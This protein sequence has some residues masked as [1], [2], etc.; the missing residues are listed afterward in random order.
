MY[1][2]LLIDRA[3]FYVLGLRLINSL[4]G[5]L[6]IFFI[7]KFLSLDT[8][9]YYYTFL[10]LAG[11]SVFFEFGLSTLILQ[12][13]S[14]HMGHLTFSSNVPE[15]D[16]V[17][18]D[19]LLTFIGNILRLGSI[20]AF[21]M[22]LALSIIGGMVF[23][24]NHVLL[25]P[26]ILFVFL[27]SLNFVLNVMVNVVE[28]AGKISEIARIRFFASLISAPVLW[29]LITAG[30][31]VYALSGQM[32][33][34]C[35]IVGVWLFVKYKQLF[36]MSLLLKSRQK[37][38]MF[39]RSI[40]PLQS[41][42]SISFLCNF[43]GTQAMVPIAFA[44]GYVEF[45]GRLGMT[46]QALNA[47][48]GFAITWVNSK[49]PIFGNEVARGNHKQAWATFERLARLSFVIL[50][51]LLTIFFAVISYIN[52]AGLTVATRFFS[53]ELMSLMLIG[54]IAN[55]IYSS[56]NVYL[57]AFKKDYLFHLNLYRGLF[58][59]LGFVILLFIRSPTGFVYLYLLSSVLFGGIGSLFMLKKFNRT[60]Y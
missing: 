12:Y 30:F 7:L 36:W 35:L 10:N 20:L 29:A 32:M 21:V 50:I 46:M 56:I 15:G 25:L 27:T 17:A 11:F 60:L 34:S 47:L 14:H 48:S 37:L 57:L 19:D 38:F 18:L 2:L 55:H 9:G 5:L 39:I 16:N 45:S 23:S 54:V 28:G 42:L 13:V 24:W 44:L 49:L 40:F 33:V 1:K 41:K 58:F 26:W 3:V 8:Q 43:I 22:F 53:I 6:T 4:A 31:N 51:V 52:F 59:I